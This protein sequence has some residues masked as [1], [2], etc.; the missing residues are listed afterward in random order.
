MS[1]SAPLSG[2]PANL[3]ATILTN[4]IL[5]G[6]FKTG[7]YLP[8][9]RELSRRHGLSSETFRRAL[10]AMERENLV[11][12]EP[13]HG[14]RVVGPARTPSHR[15]VPDTCLFV[16]PPGGAGGWSE[17]HKTMWMEIQRLAA[18]KSMALLTVGSDS[19]PTAGL[20]EKIRGARTAG[21]ILERHAPA[22]EVLLREHGIPSVLIEAAGHDGMD[23]VVQD[24]FQGVRQ[25]VAFL[26]GRGHKAIAWV[27]PSP[28]TAD[29]HVVERFSGYAGGMAEQRMSVASERVVE[30]PYGDVAAAR[31][32][33]RTLLSG[34]RRPTAMVAPWMHMSLAAARAAE[35]AGLE[36]NRD[37]DLVGWTTEEA[38][39]NGFLGGFKNGQVPP[40]MV[41]SVR[42][43]V[44]LAYARLEQRLENP[45]LPVAAT[46]VPM[47]LRFPDDMPD[48]G[49][50][51]L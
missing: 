7:E 49:A 40:A 13:R 20:A 5:A 33:V 11:M 41:W 39:A 1:E 9:L 26:A 44:E 46:R 38:Y 28:G 29:S 23:S 22:M 18:E 24:G 6:R 37:I 31:E 50:E 16:G 8:P 35:D 51:R 10:K 36:L 42:A 21:A 27:G 2:R 17:M 34:P 19:P 43:M 25:A 4:S 15:A 48:E 3:A 45:R 30:T 47:R 32:R 14:F 12:S